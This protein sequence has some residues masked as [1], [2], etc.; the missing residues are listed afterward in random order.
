[1]ESPKCKNESLKKRLRKLLREYGWTVDRLAYEFGLSRT[2]VYKIEN[3]DRTSGPVLRLIE[4]H[5]R[6][7]VVNKLSGVGVR[8]RHRPKKQ[9][10]GDQ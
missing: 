2:A 10:E 9:G 4:I 6:W 8:D 5:E 1:M 3:S 7:L